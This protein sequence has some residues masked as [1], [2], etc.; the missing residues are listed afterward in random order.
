[1][2]KQANKYDRSV[3]LGFPCTLLTHLFAVISFIRRL[4]GKS[5]LS[6]H[7]LVLSVCQLRK[8]SFLRAPRV[9]QLRDGV[10]PMAYAHLRLRG[11]RQSSRPGRDDDGRLQDD[12]FQIQR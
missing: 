3:V 10:F 6:I 11:P 7:V 9:L 4:P 5:H 12:C 2:P 8:N 1:M